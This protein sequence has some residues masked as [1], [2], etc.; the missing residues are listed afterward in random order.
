VR[1]AFPIGIIPARLRRSFEQEVRLTASDATRMDAASARAVGTTPEF[2]FPFSLAGATAGFL[3]TIALATI[4]GIGLMLRLFA[5]VRLSPH[6]DEASSILAAHA[7]ASRGW[8]D[9]PSGTVYFQGATLSWLLAPLVRLGYGDLDHLAAMRMVP[10]LAG[11]LT[12]YLAYRLAMAV[13]GNGPTALAMATFVAL[14]PVSV[15]WSAHVRMYGLLQAITAG[16]AW[17]FITLLQRERSYWHALLVGLLCWLAVFTHVGAS[18]LLPAMALAALLVHGRGAWRRPDIGLALGGGGLA[19]LTLLGLN[20]L[21][22][23]ASVAAREGEG[24]KRMSFVG[25][26]LLQPVAHLS[27]AVSVPDW[28]AV[29]RPSTITWLLPGLLVALAT[30]GGG[31]VL[32]RERGTVRDAATCLL[33]L[34]WVPVLAVGIL[35][36]SPRERYLLHAHLLGYLFLAVLVTGWTGPAIRRVRSRRQEPAPIAWA[37][38]R[39]GMATLVLG[40]ALLVRLVNPVVHPDYHAA[41]AW[42]NAHHE[43]GEPIVLALPAAGYLAIDP[44]ERDD[45][46]YLAGSEDQPRSQRYTRVTPEG[47]LVDYWIGAPAIT[48]TAGLRAYLEA[49]PDAWIVIDEERLHA[50]WAYRGKVEQVLAQMTVV[51]FRARGGALVLRVR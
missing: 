32:L 6:V 12:I 8:P 22:G 33:C 42:V 41:M 21:L 46:A 3:R 15:Q 34:Y 37:M 18:L 36:A 4:V 48:T 50:D 10:V 40:T 25:D 5:A 35:T 13:T 24:G 9:L 27:G 44:H 17:A 47:D 29:L 19:T 30:V 23:M 43:P 16:L 7:T 1:D 51:E 38:A 20:R 31:R 49:N 28:S 11:C 45:L 14:D 39:L 2:P 26:N